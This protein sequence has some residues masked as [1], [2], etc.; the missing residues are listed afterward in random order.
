[1]PKE[2]DNLSDSEIEQI[3]DD[4]A[5]AFCKK[6]E[7]IPRPYSHRDFDKS[8]TSFIPDLPDSE[9]ERNLE[10]LSCGFV[11]TYNEVIELEQERM[12]EIAHENAESV[13]V[14]EEFHG[15]GSAQ[16]ANKDIRKTKM[17]DFWQKNKDIILPT[18]LGCLVGVGINVWAFKVTDK[19]NRVK[20]QVKEYEKTLP[21][22]YLEY[23]QAVEHYRDSLM[24]AKGR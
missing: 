4:D 1:M 3:L 13:R 17:Q 12:K 8:G 11:R 6:A 19:C 23:K 16:D 24:R 14:A 20:K 9:F 18:I 21:A 2:L 10:D 15:S 7:R 22:E 5:F